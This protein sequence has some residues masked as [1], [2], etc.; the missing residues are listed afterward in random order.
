MTQSAFESQVKGSKSNLVDKED[1]FNEYNMV[2]SPKGSTPAG[3]DKADEDL[4]LTH[5]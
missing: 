2:S 3:K 5:D 4:K 1:E